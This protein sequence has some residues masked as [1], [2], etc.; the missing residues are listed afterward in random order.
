[1]DIF[2]HT[3]ILKS[4]KIYPYRPLKPCG[5]YSVY[6]K[7][8]NIEILH[9]K[10]FYKRFVFDKYEEGYFKKTKKNNMNVRVVLQ[11]VLGDTKKNIIR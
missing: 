4:F 10:Q 9:F 6:T 1:M 11:L 8:V 3:R 2:P 5:S 7:D